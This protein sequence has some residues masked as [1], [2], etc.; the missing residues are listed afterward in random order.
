MMDKETDQK[1][2]LDQEACE[3]RVIVQ[4][5]EC[6]GIKPQT[7]LC[8]G[9]LPRGTNLKLFPFLYHSIINI[10]LR[11]GCKKPRVENFL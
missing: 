11:L 5:V 1:S 4:H 3:Q 10:Y 9:S 2:P 8:S 7:F 6:K